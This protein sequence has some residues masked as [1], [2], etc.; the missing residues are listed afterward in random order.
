MLN[1]EVKCLYSSR[2]VIFD[3]HI[4]P[5]PHTLFLDSS[6]FCPIPL[7]PPFF[8]SDTSFWP[9]TSSSLL[10]DDCSSSNPSFSGACIPAPSPLPS[11]NSPSSSSP[12]PPRRSTRPH[13]PPHWLFDYTLQVTSVSSLFE[14]RNYLEPCQ[15]P[16]WV[17]AMQSEL[18]VLEKNST[19]VLTSLP[20]GKTA[21]NSK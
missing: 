20:S 11:F 1:L 15:F 16:Q 8:K 13:A 17:E 6:A 10:H 21:V 3:E 19:W 18:S 9:T 14:P 7:P 2:D 12:P 5:F 4:F